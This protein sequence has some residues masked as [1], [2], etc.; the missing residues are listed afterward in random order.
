MYVLG[1]KDGMFREI[2]AEQVNG[3]WIKSLVAVFMAWGVYLI[4]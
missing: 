1:K 3:V 4:N 2:Y